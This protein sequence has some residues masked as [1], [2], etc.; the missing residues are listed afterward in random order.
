MHV[1]EDPDQDPNGKLEWH[2][3]QVDQPHH[4]EKSHLPES[5]R[6]I[7]ED[8]IDQSSIAVVSNEEGPQR[9]LT[10][11]GVQPDRAGIV[12]QASGRSEAGFPREIQRA[13]LVQYREWL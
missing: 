3:H 5:P 10:V 6:R 7:A 9:I 4:R 1:G 8:Q 12:D 11:S 13:D 2:R